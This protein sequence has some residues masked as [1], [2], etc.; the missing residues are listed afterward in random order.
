LEARFTDGI[1]GYDDRIGARSIKRLDEPAHE[2]RGVNSVRI[3]SY[4]DIEIP[5]EKSSGVIDRGRLNPLGVPQEVQVDPLAH[6]TLHDLGRAV[7][8]AAVDHHERR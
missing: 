7:G 1:Q 4:E 8:T 3:A 6:E 2:P 5:P